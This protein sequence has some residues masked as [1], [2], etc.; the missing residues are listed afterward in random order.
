MFPISSNIEKNIFRQ[1]SLFTFRKITHA[2]THTQSNLNYFVLFI[3]TKKLTLGVNVNLLL[4][5]AFFGT[6]LQITISF[7]QAL[8][9]NIRNIG[10]IQ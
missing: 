9:K 2:H 5:A 6:K 4:N 10:A 1:R 3:E 8:Y 7:Q